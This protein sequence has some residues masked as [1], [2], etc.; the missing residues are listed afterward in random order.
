M[1]FD[2]EFSNL[3][4]VGGLIAR[5]AIT[6][7]EVTEMLL[8]RIQRID[9]G[10]RAYARVL[11]DRALRQAETADREIE[12]GLHRGPIHG[13]PIAV[14]DLCWIKGVATAAGTAV[15]RDFI[16]TR[17]ATVVRRLVEAGAVLI[18]KTQLTEGAYSDYHPSISPVRNPW[19][20]EYWA[21]I[22]SSGSAVATA[23]GLCF[24]S[25]ASDT[26]G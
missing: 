25:I 16:S 23:A 22:S 17:D 18:G 19:N 7:K 4:E 8:A 6:S 3:T 11:D 2:V 10:L 26:G 21:G 20:R 24:G 15:H 14:K 5:R 9:G 13:I 1:S 12:E